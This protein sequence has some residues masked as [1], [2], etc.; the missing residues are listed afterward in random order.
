MRLLYGINETIWHKHFLYKH[1]HV[2]Q[3]LASVL[4]VFACAWD[5]RSI[6]LQAVSPFISWSGI[7]WKQPDTFCNSGH[8]NAP[9]M[10]VRRRR[11]R[12]G[13]NNRKHRSTTNRMSAQ[14]WTSVLIQRSMAQLTYPSTP[15]PQPHH[16]S[17][18]RRPSY[19]YRISL[20]LR[21]M[22][23]SGWHRR[24]CLWI[25]TECRAGQ[26]ASIN[27]RPLSLG[28]VHSS[29]ADGS[30]WIS[31]FYVS[32]PDNPSTDA[33]PRRLTVTGRRLDESCSAAPAAATDV[34]LS[35]RLYGKLCNIFGGVTRGS[36]GSRVDQSSPTLTLGR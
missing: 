13:P 15:P 18:A 29:R 17:S 20:G 3:S 22:T 26:P 7:N 2:T 24:P 33:R 1:S 12:E 30:E 16:H 32:Y 34:K 6:K 4:P 25:I 27:Q 14:P 35:S 11:I 19:L 8:G 28:V 21:G 23:P 36:S 5:F 31:K 10:G 9:A